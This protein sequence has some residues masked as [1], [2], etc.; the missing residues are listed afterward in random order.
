MRPDGRNQTAAWPP[1]GVSA[2]GLQQNAAISLGD[3]PRANFFALRGEVADKR[4][5]TQAGA[6]VIRTPNGA[7]RSSR[8]GTGRMQPLDE[9][10]SNSHYEA[11]R[12]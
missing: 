2:Q 10:F 9:N 5:Y 12:V 8:R 1:V 7:A 3:R 4:A 11:D 6:F